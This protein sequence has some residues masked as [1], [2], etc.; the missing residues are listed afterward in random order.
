MTQF[1]LIR[2]GETAWTRER[3]YQGWTDTALTALGKKQVRGAVKMARSWG[4]DVMYTSALQRAVVSGNIL[5][6]ALKMTPRQ[7]VRLNE[8]SFGEWEGKTGKELL[9][10][11]DAAYLKWINGGRINPPGGESIGALKKRIQ[12]FIE[13]GLRRHKDKK[14]VVVSHGGAIR[15]FLMA[16]LNLPQKFLFNFQIDPAS[17]TVLEFHKG[18]AQVVCLNCRGGF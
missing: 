2:H 16:A 8:I 9:A 15:M 18:H 3:R 17:M 5:A 1:I 4:A 11:K 14:I 7:D 13:D 12:D 10:Q 6:A